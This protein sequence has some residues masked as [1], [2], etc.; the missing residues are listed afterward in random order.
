MSFT[1][2]FVNFI[3]AE[4]S[5]FFDAIFI[6]VQSYLSER[7]TISFIPACIISFA[8]SLHGNNAT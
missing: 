5:I 1:S 3:Q 8:H 7:Y 2:S 6:S 4:F